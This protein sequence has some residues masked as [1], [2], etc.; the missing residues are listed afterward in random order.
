MGI[1]SDAVLRAKMDYVHTN[2]VKRGLV[3][4]PSQWPWS[5]LAQLLP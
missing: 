1:T 3:D 5:S 2:P 4:D